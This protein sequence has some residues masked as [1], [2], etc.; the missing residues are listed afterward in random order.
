MKGMVKVNFTLAMVYHNFPAGND[1]MGAAV[2]NLHQSFLFS[3]M[4]KLSASLL[5]VLLAL[6]S[7]LASAQ[8]IRRVNNTGLTGTNIYADLTAAQTAASNGDIIQVEPSS[9]AYPAF[10]CTKQLTI[11]GPGYFL[12]ENQ[13]PVLQ[14]SSI[15]ST[16]GAITFSA[17]SAGTTISGLIGNTNWYIATNNITIQRCYITG[18]IYTGYGLVTTGAVIR[19]NYFYGV[20]ESSVAT[21]SLITN[22]I[23]Y[24]Q[25][26]ITGAGNTGEFTN[27]SVVGGTVNLNAFTVRNNYFGSTFN[28][29]VNTSWS[30]NFL[31]AATLPT[32]GSQSNNTANVTQ[33]SIF[34]LTPTSF[35][36]FD[37]W[38]KLKPAPNTALGA[39]Q[40]GVDIGATGSATGYGYRFAGLPGI[41]AIYQLNQV[42]TGN[43]LNVTIGT[44][45]NN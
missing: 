41:P 20:Q 43:N 26:N 13:P 39:G 31:A 25:T 7:Q 24:S 36:Q 33:A 22:N 10:N 1:G 32:P 18:Y 5:F 9:A 28:P 23:M 3:F 14:A 38:Y 15:A 19:Q 12:T 2:I 29:T 11:V 40:G 37:G 45:S 6:A 44:R 8:T 27:N 42:V 34:V 35:G 17:G 4:K 30:Y 16:I 21:N